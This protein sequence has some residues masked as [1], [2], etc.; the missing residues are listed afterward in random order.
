MIMKYKTKEEI[1]VLALL[2]GCKDV[3]W[4]VEGYIAAQSSILDKP[5]IEKVNDFLTEL[6][7]QA[8]RIELAAEYSNSEMS[9][10]QLEERKLIFD[11]IGH[12][13]L[14]LKM[15]KNKERK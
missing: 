15:N 4:F 7:E 3:D 12:V 5:L 11:I 13:G 6:R 1:R 8:E 14:C 9:D 10:S 2:N